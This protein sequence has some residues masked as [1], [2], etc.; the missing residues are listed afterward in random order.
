MNDKIK[1]SQSHDMNK[2]VRSS[3]AVLLAGMLAVISGCIYTGGNKPQ[4]EIRAS[5]ERPP[6]VTPSECTTQEFS[7]EELFDNTK[8]SIAVVSTASSLGSAF[9]IQQEGNSTFLIT[10]AH[11]V[12]GDDVVSLKWVDGSQDRA[13]VIKMG[14]S[15]TAINDLALL[16]VSG[17]NRKPLN[18]KQG[19]ARTGADIIALGAPRGLEFTITKG[20]VSAVR[21]EGRLI[22]IDAPINPGNSGGPILDQTGCV[23]G[24]STFIYID[25]DG[26]GFAI[27]SDQLQRFLASKPQSTNQT[28]EVA[29]K[30]SS[31]RSRYPQTCWTSAHPD[32]PE[33]KLISLGCKVSNPEPGLITVEWSDGYSTKFRNYSD[34]RDEIEDVASGVIKYGIINNELIEKDGKQYLVVNADDGAESWIPSDTFQNWNS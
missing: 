8:K 5:T 16:E 1:K 21:E 24:V 10:N 33:G 6:R 9:V 14:D 19:T 20:I 34:R 23:V 15:R 22:Q 7:A 13:A 30:I 27:S 26:L 11:V 28:G 25:S 31:S 32:A 12:E 2:R 4:Y 17:I 29:P 3:S 18:I